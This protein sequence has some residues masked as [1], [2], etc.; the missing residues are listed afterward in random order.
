MTRYRTLRDCGSVG[1]TFCGAQRQG[2][3]LEKYGPK[4]RPHRLI[5]KSPLRQRVHSPLSPKNA[6]AYFHPK[7]ALSP[8][9]STELIS[10]RLLSFLLKP[11]KGEDHQTRESKRGQKMPTKSLSDLWCNVMHE[12]PMW[13]IHGHYKCRAC[14]RI[15][16]VPW[17]EADERPKQA[18]F[19]AFKQVLAGRW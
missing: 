12:S 15:Y 3:N 7:R 13:P 11:S 2:E 16:R 19:P 18:G 6:P 9:R 1:R 10:R 5:S 14:G 8:L 17:T 4:P